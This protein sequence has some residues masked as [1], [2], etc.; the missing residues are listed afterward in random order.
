MSATATETTGTE[1]DS[2]ETEST[3]IEMAE[4][5]STSQFGEFSAILSDLVEDGYEMFRGVA[6]IEV[7]RNGELVGQLMEIPSGVYSSPVVGVTMHFGSVRDGILHI[8]KNAKCV[9]KFKPRKAKAPAKLTKERA[10]SAVTA[11]ARRYYRFQKE[12]DAARRRLHVAETTYGKRDEVRSVDAE[13]AAESDAYQRRDKSDISTHHAFY[14][15]DLVSAAQNAVDRAAD[16]LT[17][18]R[19]AM[20][21]AVNT[22]RELGAVQSEWE[23]AMSV[24]KPK[25]RAK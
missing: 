19:D 7:K 4:G 8:V 9:A 2:L 20:E 22:A 3:E 6:F 11:N 12:L 10:L 18:R 21:S 14:A 5:H 15:K 25:P 23:H 17:V 1:L 16:M 13:R 24:A